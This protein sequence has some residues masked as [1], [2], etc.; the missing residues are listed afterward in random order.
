MS[1]VTT[2]DKHYKAIADKL[3]ENGIDRSLKPEEMSSALGAAVAVKYNNGFKAGDA[4]GYERGYSVGCM[5][6]KLVGEA[7]GRQAL[8]T[9]L[10]GGAW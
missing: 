8:E 3:R 1:I 10:L 2:D 4:E 6:G 5:E 7:N 9:E